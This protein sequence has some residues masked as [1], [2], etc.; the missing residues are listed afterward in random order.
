MR[1]I[2]R[3]PLFLMSRFGKYFRQ[4]INRPGILKVTMLVSAYLQFS[5]LPYQRTNK[6]LPQQ[7]IKNFSDYSQTRVE[8]K[9][10][11]FFL[12]LFAIFE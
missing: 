10:V 5:K 9:F 6:F 3:G 1:K 2:E 11:L 12:Q 7:S 4:G 8:S